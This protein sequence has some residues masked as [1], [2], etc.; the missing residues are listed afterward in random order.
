M[1]IEK[2]TGSSPFLKAGED[3][4]DGDIITFIDE[5]EVKEGQL[6][7]R[8]QISVKTPSGEEKTLSLNPTS[9][10]YMIDAYGTETSEWVDQEAKCH[11]MKTMIDG[12]RT[13][14][15]VLTHP[16]KDLEE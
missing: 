5:G 13:T 15:V 16:D 4:K 12:K 3:V 11:I 1:K 2:D 14:Y 7:P 8:L 10:G 6:G 9:K